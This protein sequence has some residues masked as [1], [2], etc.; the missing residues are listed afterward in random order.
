VST[1]PVQG[2]YI[3][4]DGLNQ[5]VATNRT[6]MMGISPGTHI[7]G[8]EKSGYQPV[9]G[10]YFT[11]NNNQYTDISFTLWPDQEN[12]IGMMVITSGPVP[13]E[14]V[15]NGRPTG[16]MTPYS[17]QYPS[18]T[19]TVGVRAS[20]YM[21]PQSQDLRIFNKPV[22]AEFT[23]TP[24]S[25][26]RAVFRGSNHR[27]NWFFDYNMDGIVEKQDKFGKAGDIPLVGD[28]NNDGTMDRAVFREKIHEKFHNKHNG[29]NWFSDYNM[30]GTI[31][32][33][34]T[35][36]KAGDIPLV[37]DFNNDRTMDRAVFREN[38]RG[39]NWFFDYNMDG[40]IDRQDR[41]GQAGDI[42]VVGDFNR[43]GIMDRAVF[44]EM[45]K[46]NNWFID[47]N[48]DGTIDRQDRFGQ[49]GDIPLVGDFNND[50]I[51]DRAVFREVTRGNNWFIDYR[52]DG[53]IDAQNKFGQMGDLPVV[54]SA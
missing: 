28:F 7:I 25:L 20:G 23:L 51:M 49:M 32:K 38:A 8:V 10:E 47:Y 12:G 14:V 37:G 46:G 29:N 52:M 30:D 35:F 34:D 26:H 39:N 50:G 13:A 6:G 41:F 9:S 40:T 1:V 44:R 33:K 31:N 53:T 16:R 42:P 2:A 21:T 54:W 22:R 45:A 36:G 17:A 15:V 27:T 24:G 4:L 3:Y 48:M 18:G 43:D 5:S 11:K 19:Y